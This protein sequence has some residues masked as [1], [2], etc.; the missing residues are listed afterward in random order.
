VYAEPYVMNSHAVFPRVQA[1]DYDGL[2]TFGGVPRK[3]IY[4]EYAD[5][6]AA[7]LA[8]YYSRR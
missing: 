3:S 2:R 4:R 8:N 1:G 6:I 5:G 7:G